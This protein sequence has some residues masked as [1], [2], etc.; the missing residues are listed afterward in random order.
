M[1]CASSI[2]AKASSSG[3]V[4]CLA[5]ETVESS[6]R[7]RDHCKSVATQE[8]RVH[9][10][11]VVTGCLNEQDDRA[12]SGERWLLHVVEPLDAGGKLCAAPRT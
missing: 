10:Q 1:R 12:S 7:D 2:F 11:A 3:F 8:R 9:F 5:A 4:S 6:I